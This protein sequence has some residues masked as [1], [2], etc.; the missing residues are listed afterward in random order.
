MKNLV[1]IT[2]IIKPPNTPLSYGI[3]SVYTNEER[4]EQTKLTIK[5]IKEKIPDSET[6][7]VEC[8]DL[9][10]DENNYF[11]QNST[12]FVNLYH[13]INLRNK[14][15]SD[16]KSLCEGTMT[17]NALEYLKNQNISYDNLIKISGRYYLSAN[18]NYINFNNDKIIIKYIDKN[19]DNVFTGLYKIP[20][21]CV[22]KLRDFLENNYN[23]MLSYIGY[24]ILFAEFVKTQI[25]T[26]IN[27]D[28]IGLK[29][30]VSVSNDFYNG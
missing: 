19:I 11:L 26:K 18:F 30:Y 13:N 10:E 15:H 28:P 4:F 29:G 16:S 14:M 7:I 6:F 27:I 1:L 23:R 5:S 3:R 21:I 24:E 20:S 22:D 8:S 17:I 25:I 2:S 9:N 12:Y